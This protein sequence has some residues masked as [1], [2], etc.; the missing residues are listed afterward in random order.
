LSFSIKGK[1]CEEISSALDREGIAVR[2][3][4]HCAQPALRRFGHEGV[5]RASLA[6]YNTQEEIDRF[7]SVVSQTVNGNLYSFLL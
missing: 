5:V 3:G 2:A 6:M 1:D 4:H 7:V